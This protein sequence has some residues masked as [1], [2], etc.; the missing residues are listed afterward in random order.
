MKIKPYYCPKCREFLRKSEVS[1]HYDEYLLSCG[2]KEVDYYFCGRCG[3]KVR[4]TAETLHRL[5]IGF[6]YVPIEKWNEVK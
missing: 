1:K 3:N 4:D 5:I 6:P 2:W